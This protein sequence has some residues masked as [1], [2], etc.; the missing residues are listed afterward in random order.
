MARE[1]EINLLSYPCDE[2][3]RNAASFCS[4]DSYVAHTVPL[5]LPR[6]IWVP[7]WEHQR[8]ESIRTQAFILGSLPLLW[9]ANHL[10]FMINTFFLLSS[11]CMS[12]IQIAAIQRD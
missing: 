10:L 9:T 7:S 11:K 3:S 6:L 2:I 8:Q 12:L 1:K 5:A 4:L